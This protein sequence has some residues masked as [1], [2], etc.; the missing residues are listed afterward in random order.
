MIAKKII[1]VFLAFPVFVGCEHLD[2]RG[3]E[4]V[5]ID[6]RVRAE[7]EIE[8]S[9][10]EEALLK[11]NYDQAN[12]LF[13][14]FEKHFP[15]SVFYQR[16]QLGRAESLE[17]QEN[18]IEAVE[19]YR[20]VVVATTDRQNELT[21]KALYRL[22][23]CY[24]NLG[25]EARVLASLVDAQRLKEFLMPEQGLA[26][27]PSRLAASYSRMGRTK[28]AQLNFRL[29]EAGV[30]EVKRLRG[31]NVTPE[32]TAE[33]YHR[34]GAFSTHQLSHENLQTSLDT[35]KTVQI[36]SLR[37]IEAE[38][39]HWSELS[40][41]GLMSNY[42][43][44]WNTIQQYPYNRAMESGAAR[45][46]Q[47]ERQAHFAGQLLAMMNDL[48]L[49]RQPEH[50]DAKGQIG[51]LFKFVKKLELQGRDFLNALGDQTPLTPEAKKREGLKREGIAIK[52]LLDPLINKL[53]EKDPN[54]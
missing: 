12:S 5:P 28:E 50:K 35:L 2:F 24:E 14:E 44:I 49:Y 4:G 34:M 26:E 42:R 51:Q 3:E 13:I 19:L 54:L 48:N 7:Q 31:T 36:F 20:Q 29:A 17:Q 11:R 16:A 6:P 25:D 1:L 46:E 21:A 27:I 32:W 9:K 18:W 37:S 39:A 15:N 45:R 30:T 8:I 33:I 22:S 41:K 47:I 52:P 53:P 40:N 38:G 43:D 10:A 23:F